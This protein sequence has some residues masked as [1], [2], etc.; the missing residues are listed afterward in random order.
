MRPVAFLLIFFF[1]ARFSF[2]KE[3]CI[4]LV[5]VVFRK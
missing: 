5:D 3:L 2:R 1:Y 4:K